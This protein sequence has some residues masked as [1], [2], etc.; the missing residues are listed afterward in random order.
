MGKP[1]IKSIFS[2][3][4][5]IVSSLRKIKINGFLGGIII[6]A[7][8]SML[9]NI[10]TVQV[11]EAISKQRILEAIENEITSNMLQ[12]SNVLTENND[13]QQNNKG[14]NNFHTFRKYSRDLWEQSTEPLQYIAQLDQETQIK[15]AGYYTI[16]VPGANLVQDKFNDISG[17]MMSNCF[18]EYGVDVINGKLAPCNKEYYKLLQLESLST[19]KDMFEQGYALLQQFHPT[20]DRLNNWF[21]RLMMGDKSMR[22]LSGK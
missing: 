6:G 1:N 10:F 17:R 5:V 11:Q 2:A 21:L 13:T 4:L 14:I 3:P 15:L 9:V 12:A 19:S 18:D 16:S 8:F 7:L 20:A 22:I